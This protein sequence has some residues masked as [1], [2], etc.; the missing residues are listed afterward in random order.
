[1]TTSLNLLLCEFK[2]E[3]ILSEYIF[4]SDFDMRTKS[5]FTITVIRVV[6]FGLSYYSGN[7]TDFKFPFYPCFFA[8]FIIEFE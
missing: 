2:Y 5:S 1:M 8:G 6:T 4:H 7:Q 3:G